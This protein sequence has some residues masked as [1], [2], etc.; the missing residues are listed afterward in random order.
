MRKLLVRKLLLF[1]C[2]LMGCVTMSQ[3]QTEAITG[4]I[5]DSLGSPIPA[6][7]IRIKGT[8]TASVADNEG[9]FTIKASAGQVL[10]ISSSGI[11]TKEI[12]VTAGVTSL[13]VQVGYSSQNLAEVTVTTALGVKRQ[14]RELGYSTAQ[15]KTAELTQAAPIN[16]ATGLAAKVSGV[17]IR[18]SDNGVN[19]QVKV[20]FRGSRSIE[21]NNSALVVVDGIPVDQ[22]YLAN[23]NPNEIEDITILKGSNA[24]AL[25]GMAASNGVMLITTK[26]GRGKF[27]LT[28]QNTVSAESI[29]YFPALQNTYSG[30]GGE[31]GSG[32]NPAGGTIYFVNPLTGTANT[33]PF[34]NEAY[35]A[36]YASLD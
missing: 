8:K 22:Q 20:T 36:P 18:L 7:T 13:Q 6:A 14:A 25:Y 30:Y 12:R 24:A 35:G 27:S 32:P 9:K 28:Y 11:A 17:D 23:I 16:A 5:T 4:R 31:G 19:P 33:V 29:S 1:F 15:I 26:K 2:F 34:E 21:G 10:I 3:A